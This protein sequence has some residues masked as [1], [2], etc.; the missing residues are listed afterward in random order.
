MAPRFYFDLVGPFETIRDELGAESD[1]FEHAVEYGLTSI[2]QMKAQGELEELES[3]W[4]LVVRDAT[5]LL[6]ERLPIGP[7]RAA[8]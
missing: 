4:T 1:T 8:E 2:E 3:G 7:G 6:Q 5:G